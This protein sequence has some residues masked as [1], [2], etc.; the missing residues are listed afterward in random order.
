MGRLLLQNNGFPR[1]LLDERDPRIRDGAKRGPQ[2]RRVDDG[3]AEPLRNRI[4]NGQLIHLAQLI[5][6][7]DLTRIRIEH[8]PRT[9]LVPRHARGDPRGPLALADGANLNQPGV[10]KVRHAVGG[11]PPGLLADLARGL[12]L[13]RE[14]NR[15]LFLRHLK[16]AVQRPVPRAGP[17]CGHGGRLFLYIEVRDQHGHAVLAVNSHGARTPSGH[18]CD[19]AAAGLAVFHAHGVNVGARTVAGPLEVSLAAF[20]RGLSFR[21]RCLVLSDPDAPV[22]RVRQSPAIGGG[23][24]QPHKFNLSAHGGHPNARGR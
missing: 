20:G 1:T 14:R 18:P 3:Q 5:E 12:K 22:L 2:C 7:R 19:H 13:H 21:V 16:N 6:G 9:D 4:S 15:N 10:A 17:L 23:A 24:H 8:G 11:T